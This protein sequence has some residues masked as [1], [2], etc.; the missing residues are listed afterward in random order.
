MFVLVA[1]LAL[2]KPEPLELRTEQQ[3]ASGEHSAGVALKMRPGGCKLVF[4][5]GV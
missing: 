1:N 2:H 4:R 3:A 5:V